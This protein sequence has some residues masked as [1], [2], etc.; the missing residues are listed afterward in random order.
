MQKRL[1]QRWVVLL[2]GSETARKAPFWNAKMM[3]KPIFMVFS[4]L[5]LTK[6]A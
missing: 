4:A 6:T 3:G 2:E 1:A 5:E